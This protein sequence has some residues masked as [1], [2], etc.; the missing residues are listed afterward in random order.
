MPKISKI[1][2]YEREQ[3]ELYLKMGKSQRW[4][5]KRLRRNHTDV[6]R[7]VKRNGGAYLP[8]RAA[9]AQRIH[10]ARQRKKNK[11]KLEKFE[12]AKV[13]EFVVK[14]L[15]EDFS[16]DQIAGRLKNQPPQELTGLTVSHESIYMK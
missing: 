5:G 15:R 13:K 7:E 1:T 6:L 16:P 2:Y 9:D 12:Y 10:E 3:I 11:K 8:Y 4:I 14:N